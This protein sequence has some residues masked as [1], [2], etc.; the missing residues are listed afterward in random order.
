MTVSDEIADL[1]VAATGVGPGNG[2]AAKVRAAMSSY[3]AGDV[4]AACSSLSDLTKQLAALA[5]KKVSPSLA[6]AL[7]AEATAIAGAMGCP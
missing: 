7:V 6:E 2:F 1:L 3:A 4:A 5:G